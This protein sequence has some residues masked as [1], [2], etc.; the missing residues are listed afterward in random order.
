[1]IKWGDWKSNPNNGPYLVHTSDNGVI[2]MEDMGTEQTG[3]QVY[4]SEIDSLI[5]ALKQAKREAFLASPEYHNIE[6][7]RNDT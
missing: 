4:Y 7:N 6:E 3:V 1:M 2:I 5:E